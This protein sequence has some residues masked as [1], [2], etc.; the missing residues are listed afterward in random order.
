MQ[1]SW[2]SDKTVGDVFA[3]ASAVCSLDAMVNPLGT[4]GIVVVL[5]KAG[6]D[7]VVLVT[8]DAAG[9]LKAEQVVGKPSKG[10][11]RVGVAGARIGWVGNGWLPVVFET[12][13]PTV[14]MQGGVKYLWANS[15]QEVPLPL[16][17]V[18]ATLD[19]ASKDGPTLP[20]AWRG[21]TRP[22]PSGTAMTVAIEAA[23]D[24][25]GSLHLWS[26]KP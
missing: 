5:R 8:R 21:L 26:W 4:L 25:S 15:A 22:V 1:A 3:G 24:T 12:L 11:C 23:D 2:T 20:L 14:P 7:Q 17:M 18:A 10:D 9:G 6:Q 16:G 13:G 19:N